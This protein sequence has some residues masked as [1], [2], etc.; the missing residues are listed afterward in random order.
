MDTAD[1]ELIEQT[2]R[3]EARPETVFSFFIDPQKMVMW[4]GILA[5]LDPQPGG[6]YQV[7]ISP[8][9]IVRGEF[10]ELAPYSR[11]V[12]T[13]GWEGKNSPLPPGSSRVEVN[14][15]EDQGATLLTL[16]HLGLPAAVKAGHVEGWEHF[17]P[18]LAAAAEGRDLGPDP[19]SM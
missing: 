12:F 5:S 15:V 3:I 9:D 16:R 10:L 11:I 7:E 6:L 13:W 19:W 4:K 14:L 8:N 18:R 1:S 17:L 2:I